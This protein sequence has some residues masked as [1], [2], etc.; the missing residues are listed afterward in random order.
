MG[1]SD[2]SAKV[3]EQLNG[4]GAPWLVE[5]TFIKDSVV[6][7]FHKTSGVIDVVDVGVGGGVPDKNAVKEWRSNFAQRVPVLLTQTQEPKMQRLRK[8][9][10]VP[11]HCL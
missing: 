7:G 9:S 6:T 11:Y 5:P 1:V 10:F 2:G 4:W 3:I 8:F